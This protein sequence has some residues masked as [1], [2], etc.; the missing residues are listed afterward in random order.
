M[1]RRVFAP[2]PLVPG[3][4]VELDDEESH[5]LLRVRRARVGDAV[6]VFDGDHGGCE[7]TLV[8]IAAKRCRVALTTPL[9]FPDVAAIELGLALL[10][11]K[12]ALDALSR[13]CEGGAAR[14]TWIRTTRC[15]FDAPSSARIGRV[16]R[17]AQRQCGRPTRPR[18]AGPIDLEA[19]LTASSTPGWVAWQDANPTILGPSITEARIL[20]GPEGGFTAAEIEAARQAGLC[21]LSLGPWI[22]RAEVAV[23]AALARILGTSTRA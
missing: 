7:G 2:A 10:D 12:A 1:S 17:A 22:L 8:E 18:V 23:T 20:V 11:P 9:E 15:Q 21:P 19:W 14:V 4:T 6:D 13:A 16:L 5:Y 3:S